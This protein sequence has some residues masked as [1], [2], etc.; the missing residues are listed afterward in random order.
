MKIN[1]DEIK[2]FHSKKRLIQ[3]QIKTVQTRG[4]KFVGG[5][6][7]ATTVLLLL[8]L[9][10][11]IQMFNCQVQVIKLKIFITLPKYIPQENKCGS[12]QRGKKTDA[13]KMEDLMIFIHMTLIHEGTFQIK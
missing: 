4:K 10:F 11:S 2:S 7:I 6:A 13:E 12:E 3:S 5:T 1:E 9:L 8:L